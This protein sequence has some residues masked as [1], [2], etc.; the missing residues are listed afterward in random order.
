M[1]IK[2][3][4]LYIVATPIGNSGD[5][6]AR[7]K[8]TLNLVDVVYAEDTRRSARLFAEHGLSTRLVSMH[9]HNEEGR[10]AQILGQLEEGL[11]IAVVSDAGTPLISD[12]GYQLVSA[13]HASGYSVSPVPGA[14]SLIAALSVSGLPTD[15]FV[16]LGFPPARAASRRSWLERSAHEPHTIVILES[17]H[18]IV[19]SLADMREVFGGHR[20]ATVARELTKTYE[21]VLHGDLAGLSSA[22]A[23]SEDQQKGEF[24]VLVAGEKNKPAAGEAELLRVVTILLR[25][26]SVS[27]SAQL[28]SELTGHR[29]KEAYALALKI[30]SEN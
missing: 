2:A 20:R 14:S 22:V 10:V 26:H 15:S 12:P 6:S 11:A 23:G 25:D 13:C 29:K 3:G 19:E 18:R 28:A 27:Q 21:T 5:F 30:D 16:F 9:E 8:E 17:R 7:A 24:V 1:S 4:T